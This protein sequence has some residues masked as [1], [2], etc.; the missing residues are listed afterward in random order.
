MAAYNCTLFL[1]TGFNTIN[2]PDSPALVNG[3][4]SISVSAL[5]INQERFLPYVR[6]R[7]TWDQ[8]KNADYCKV[9]DFYYTINSIN[10]TSQDVA[11]ISLTPDFITSA[12]GPAAL[13]ILDGITNRV[14]V[15]NDAFGL[16]GADDPYMAPAYDMDIDSYQVII[17]ANSTTFVE[18]TLSLDSMGFN[19]ENN[20]MQAYT[21]YDQNDETG[22]KSVVVPVAAY[23]AASTT[24]NAEIGGGTQ[25]LRNVKKQGLFSLVDSDATHVGQ[26]MNVAR[27]LGIENAISG[28]FEIPNTMFT[29][30]QVGAFVSSITGLTQDTGILGLPFI[31]GTANNNRVWYGSQSSYTLV[32]AAGNTL[33]AKPE[34]IYSSGATVPTVRRIVDPRRTGKPYYRFMPLN[35]NSGNYDFFRGCVAGN[36]WDSVPLVLTEKSGGLLDRANY[37]ASLA[38]RDLADTYEQTAYDWNRG[39]NMI[40]IGAKTIAGS[41]IGSAGVMGANGLAGAKAGFNQ[42]GSGIAGI[43]N[44]ELGHMAYQETSALERQL[45]KSQFQISQNVNV[46]DVKFPMT[47][48]LM[49]EVL[50]NGFMVFR[51]KY[52][53]Q[54]IARIDK[55]LTAFGYKFVKVLETS[56]FT[57][58][59]KFNY[60]EGSIT[61][62][63]NLPRWWCNGISAQIAGGVRV[64]HIKP[65]HTAYSSNP[66][67]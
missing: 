49:N 42:F 32:S 41:G 16:Y 8:I 12:G 4:T 57:N 50:H 58:R 9:G 66:I 36:P 45:E 38:R 64:W 43:G 6:V 30:T 39:L 23:L 17:A 67:A 52:K 53:A 62:G 11:E 55:I 46:P 31:Y 19:F 60:V 14:H 15:S 29:A 37:S 40:G 65:T 25:A 3:M 21:A 26:G 61:V 10:M 33:T 5:D 63:G 18:T 1:N 44:F 48:D 22:E 47:P 7:A 56:D 34:E 35:G 54:D 59:Q 51:N 13:E 2:I 24:Y 27:S 28:Q 20:S